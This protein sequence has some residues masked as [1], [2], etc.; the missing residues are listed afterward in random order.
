MVQ[1]ILKKH[2]EACAQEVFDYYWPKMQAVV[3]ES[4]SPYDDMILAAVGP[5]VKAAI[6]AKIEEI[7]QAKV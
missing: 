1:E 5:S 4:Q 2:V 6:K 3:A 7:Y